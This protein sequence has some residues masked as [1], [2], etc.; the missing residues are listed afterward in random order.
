MKS[1][2]LALGILAIL[3]VASSAWAQNATE[4]WGKAKVGI[5]GQI[6]DALNAMDIKI[7][8]EKTVFKYVMSA[9]DSVADYSVLNDDLFGSVTG[10][11]DLDIFVFIL[12]GPGKWYME[13]IDC[14]MMG[15]TMLGIGKV[16]G[17]KVQGKATSPAIVMLGPV[18]SSAPFAI[19][20]VIVA[21]IPP[22]T[23]VFPAGYDF[24]VWY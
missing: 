17:T 20:I 15:D 16:A 19:G 6:E 1:L 14:C 3:L 23:G 11:R 9:G 13:I 5:D 8:P 2:K 24:M 18:G 12:K 21:Y 10:T 22:H 4:A 7:T